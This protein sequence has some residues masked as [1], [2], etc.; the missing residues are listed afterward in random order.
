MTR[1]SENDDSHFL[2]HPEV[3]ELFSQLFN[4]VLAESDRGAVLVGTSYVDLNLKKLFEAVAPRELSQKRLRAILDYPGPLSTFAARTQVAFLCRL[5]WSVYSAI[6]ALR[7][8]RNSIAHKPDEFVLADHKEERQRIYSLGPG[9]PV[10]V[11]RL[12]CELLGRTFLER[13][14][15][16]RLP[17]SESPIFNSPADVINYITDKPGLLAPLNERLPRG[18]LGILLICAFI[19]HSREAAVRACGVSSTWPKFG[20]AEQGLAPDA[21]NDAR[22]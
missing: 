18:E 2:D 12:A 7:E 3:L 16:I 6:E 10:W 4:N 19:I 14:V 9:V 11:N 8:I 17:D 20:S 15:E 5:N 1:T 21:H 22:G 13:A